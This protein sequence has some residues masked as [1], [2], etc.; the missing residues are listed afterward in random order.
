M[1]G[2]NIGKNKVKAR[3]MHIAHGAESNLSFIQ[4]ANEARETDT[5]GGL[6][7][8]KNFSQRAML[9]QDFPSASPVSLFYSG[10]SFSSGDLE[11]DLERQFSV[12]KENN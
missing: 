10:G 4:L 2:R 11:L 1:I 3:R 5:G 9:A 7:E 12:R 6:M 8:G